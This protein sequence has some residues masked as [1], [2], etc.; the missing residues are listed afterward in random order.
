[1]KIIMFIILFLLIGA[2]FIISNENLRI[3]SRENVGEFVGLYG[4]WLDKLVRNSGTVVGY[5]IRMEW[6][7]EEEPS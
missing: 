6:L 7:P 1:M 2:F 5:V 3:N 4:G